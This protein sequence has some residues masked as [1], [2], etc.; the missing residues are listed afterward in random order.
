MWRATGDERPKLKIAKANLHWPDDSSVDFDLAQTER[1]RVT[2][3]N[4]TP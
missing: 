3:R 1:T 4:G 2:A